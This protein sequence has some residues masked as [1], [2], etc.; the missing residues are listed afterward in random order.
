[1]IDADM[2]AHWE[3]LRVR[4]VPG[5]GDCVVQRFAYTCGLIV[6]VTLDRVYIDY[7]ARYCYDT[8]REALHALDTWDG[9]GDPP[10]EWIREKESGRFGPG[11]KCPICKQRGHL[12]EAAR[13]LPGRA[14]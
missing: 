4:D 14:P 2:V 10:G 8:A 9:R 5:R 7:A 6:G 12:C 3:L 11:A 1:M 13:S